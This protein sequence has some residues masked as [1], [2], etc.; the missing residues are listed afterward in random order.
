MLSWSPS[1][2][3]QIIGTL[4]IRFELNHPGFFIHDNLRTTT[5]NWPLKQRSYSDV[6]VSRRQVVRFDCIPAP[7]LLHHESRWEP[8]NP[9]YRQEMCWTLIIST[10]C[11]R[12]SHWETLTN[13]KYSLAPWPKVN[14]DLKVG[15]A[16][17][18]DA[19]AAGAGRGGRTLLR[20][21]SWDNPCCQ[22]R[23]G[24]NVING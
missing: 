20:S 18:E 12:N 1:P 24:H 23:Y 17:L 22:D 19:G 13:H 5:R 14:A 11:V 3:M 9:W 15:T 21:P 7:N 4:S 2:R 16:I 6:P 10:V 8:S